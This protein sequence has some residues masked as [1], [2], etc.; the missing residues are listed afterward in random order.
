[1]PQ[2]GEKWLLVTSTYHLP[3]AVGAFRQLGFAVEPWPV[4]DL[5]GSAAQQAAVIRHELLGLLW[6]WLAGRS[7]ELVPALSPSR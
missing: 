1:M 4:R 2:P 3:R 6:Y 7:S 5:S